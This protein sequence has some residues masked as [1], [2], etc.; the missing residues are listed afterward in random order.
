MF[1]EYFTPQASK[2][3][4]RCYRTAINFRKKLEKTYTH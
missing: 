1:V 4:L 3:G 2:L